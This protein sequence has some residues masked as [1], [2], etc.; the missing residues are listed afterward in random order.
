MKVYQYIDVGQQELI[1][2]KLYHYATAHAGVNRKWGW[3]NVDLSNLKLHVPELFEELAKIIPHPVEMVAIL[4]F[5]PKTNGE[6]HVDFERHQHRM[7]WPVR[8]CEGSYT[9]FYDL[10]GNKLITKFGKQGERY[11]AS[12]GTNPL[13][14]IAAVELIKPIVF[15]PKI[16]HGVYTNPDCDEPR[17][18]ATIGFGDYPLDKFLE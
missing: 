14:E 5:L 9:K 2:N 12:T 1:S 6:K 3:T 17:I 13:V 10:N 15:S 16:L 8:N 7:L 4:M 18:T 11:L